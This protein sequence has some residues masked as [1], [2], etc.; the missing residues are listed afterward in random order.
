MGAQAFLIRDLAHSIR[1]AG[2][3][4][5]LMNAAGQTSGMLKGRRPAADILAEMVAEAALM[6]ASDLGKRVEA[7]VA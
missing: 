6:L 5:L 2:R 4:D 3:H 1:A 7:A